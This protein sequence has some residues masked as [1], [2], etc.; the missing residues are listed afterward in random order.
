MSKLSDLVA[1]CQGYPVYIQTHNFPDPDAIAS[2]FGL[3]KLLGAYGVE[4]RLCYDGKID[5][6]SASKMLSAFR[7]EM[8]PYE[9]L[10]ADMK[11]TD[12]IICVDTQ[13]HAGNVT[14]FIGDE[15]ACIDHHPTFVPVEYK[16][17]DIRMTGACATLIAEYYALSGIAPDRDVATALLYGL[18]MDTLNLARN[19]TA[20]DIEMLGYLFPYCDPDTLADLERNNMEFTDLKAYGAAIENIELYDKV[21][22][23][24]VP[25]TCPAALV[26]I[27]SDFIL[28]LVEVEVAIVASFREDGIKLSVR[29][30][31]PE[32]HAGNLLHKALLGI[33]NGGGHAT[34]GGGFISKERV[35]E[36]GNYPQDRIRELFLDVLMKE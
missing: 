27:L 34:M 35:P 11:E 5:K 13:K 31:D 1:L 8:S 24:Y 26:A 19:V 32:V 10:I 20:L 7:M 17:Q 23:S 22:I 33:G 36:L 25:F 2:A 28:A 12:R 14:D 3:Q 9:S 21:G 29:S 30:E 15:V 16:Y 18:K 4:S 6:L